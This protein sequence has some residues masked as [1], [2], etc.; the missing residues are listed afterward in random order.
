ML[1][2]NLLIA[3]IILFFLNFKYK[4]LYLTSGLNALN[5]FLYLSRISKF[6]NQ[7]ALETC[8]LIDGS[9]CY[10]TENNYIKT[11]LSSKTDILINQEWINIYNN[12]PNFY[13]KDILYH[14]S[15][16]TLNYIETLSNEQDEGQN[17]K[18]DKLNIVMTFDDETTK[19]EMYLHELRATFYN[20]LLIATFE[21]KLRLSDENQ[22]TS[23]KKLKLSDYPS[24]L[25]GIIESDLVNISFNGKM[26]LFNSIYVRAKDEDSKSESINFFGYIGDKIV[27]AYSHSDK[28]RKE[29][30]WLKVYSHSTI[31]VDKL[32]ISGP[33]EIDNI[34]FTF[35]FD[36]NVDFSDI[37]SMND[38]KKEKKLVYD[39]EI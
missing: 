21:G 32:I 24:K 13:Y 5:N 25:Y 20:E 26:F 23:N 28:T 27:F 31:Y 15:Q 8:S 36:T 37:L 19:P 14:L 29:R 18:S 7:S 12:I 30:N 39:D 33:Y 38:F 34:H 11:I 3:Y 35:S 16:E 2:K 4:C 22:D 10:F 17:P 6:N 9:N 1:K